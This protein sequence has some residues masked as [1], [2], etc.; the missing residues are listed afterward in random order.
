MTLPPTTDAERQ[1]WRDALDAREA[2]L[3]SQL[4]T[5]AAELPDARR[6][7]ATELTRAPACDRVDIA[8]ERLHHGLRYAEAERD[9]AELREIEAARARLDSG[10]FGRCIECGAE[11]PH[12]RLQAQ[13]AAARCIACQAR[14]E[15]AHPAQ[16]RL[17]PDL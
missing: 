10:A 6:S 1:H 7:D 14:H 15:Q 13:P 4:R 8:G 9:M 3:A 2:A 17:P 16:V 5:V 11:I 12:A